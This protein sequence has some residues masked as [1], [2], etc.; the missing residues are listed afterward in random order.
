MNPDAF[1]FNTRH[2]IPYLN[3]QGVTQLQIQAITVDN[4]KR[5]FARSN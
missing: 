2:T 5:F 4:P 1:L 3:H